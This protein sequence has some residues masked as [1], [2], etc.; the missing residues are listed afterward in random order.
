LQVVLDLLQQPYS[1]WKIPLETGPCFLL[2]KPSETAAGRGCTLY[3]QRGRLHGLALPVSFCICAH[4]CAMLRPSYWPV[5]TCATTTA[6][7]LI[8]YPLVSSVT[9]TDRRW[10]YCTSMEV[11]TCGVGKMKY[12]TC[13]GDD[14]DQ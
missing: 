12:S 13:E 14:F 5:R 2:S 3:F 7:K 4:F 10:D 6:G 1:A 11:L 8:L 9:A